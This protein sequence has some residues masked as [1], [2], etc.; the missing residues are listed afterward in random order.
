MRV[1]IEQSNQILNIM[2]MPTA[3]WGR[4][5]CAEESAFSN[6]KVGHIVY[7]CRNLKV[8]LN[9]TIHMNIGPYY[10]NRPQNIKVALIKP[11]EFI[12]E[13]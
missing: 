12:F 5:I 2:D 9:M 8:V 1:T 13:M 11:K 6:W 10:F 3:T 7:M 4:I